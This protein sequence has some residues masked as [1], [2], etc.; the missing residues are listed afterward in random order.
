MKRELTALT[1]AMAMTLMQTPASA[2]EIT[3]I[4]P[5]GIRDAIQKMIPAFEKKTGHTVKATFGSGGGT[6]RQVMKGEAF[7][8]PIVQP[9]LQ[10]VI[11]TG[12]VV[13]STETPLAIVPVA[14][15]VRKGAPKPDI[16]TPDEI[17]RAHV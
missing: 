1:L 16:S 7:D 8:V 15:A 11:T 13:A 2:D 9:P 17:G 4:A 5:G 10:E 12:H 3:L 14:L 6:K